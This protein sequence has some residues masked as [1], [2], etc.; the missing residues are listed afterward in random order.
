MDTA[1]RLAELALDF[2]RS[3]A[4]K[5]SQHPGVAGGYA[6]IKEYKPFFVAAA[7]RKETAWQIIYMNASG[8]VDQW[9]ITIGHTRSAA[10][11]WLLAHK[12]RWG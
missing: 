6:Y 1:K 10:I 9:G 5:H 3:S 2:Q 7:G 12:K 8:R 4:Q 11:K